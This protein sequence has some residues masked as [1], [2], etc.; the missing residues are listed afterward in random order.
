MAIRQTKLLAN[1]YYHIY[2]RGNN[3]QNIFLEQENYFYFLRKIKL[4]FSEDVEILSYCLMPN[5]YHI[6][7][8]LK[9]NNFSQIMQKFTIAYTKAI[10]K[11]F[12][13]VGSLFQ[14]SFK[15]INI[16]T[17]EYLLHLSRYIHLN[18]VKANLVKH[19]QDWQFSSYLEY[20]GLRKGNLPK[21]DKILSY[22]PNQLDYQNFCESYQSEQD[23][24]IKHLILE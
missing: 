23:K 12:N 19:P 11:R 4:Y 5:H 18:P 16:S 10:N 9:N 21:T 14:G 6:L 8:Y 2:N 17:D 3:R 22:F 1:H 24:I 15:A 20:I 13:R 7:V